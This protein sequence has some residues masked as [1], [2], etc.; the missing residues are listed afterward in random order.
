MN[1]PA[2]DPP[3]R[4][5]GL[6][7]PRQR[8][9]RVV[10]VTNGLHLSGAERQML[11]VAQALVERG[12][13]VA[14]LSLLSTAAF[15][16]ELAAL[17]IPAVQLRMRRPARGVSAVVEATRLLRRWRPDVLISFVY[18]ANVLGRLA[19]R[20]A[21]VG[22]VISS[23][24][25]ERFGGRARDAVLRATDRLA[26]ITT[27][28]SVLA[29]QRLVRD[30]VVP[31]GRLHVIGNAIDMERFRQPQRRTPARGGLGVADHEFVWLTVGRLE[32][33]KD[34]ETLLAAFARVH[35][36]RPHARLLIAGDGGLA[37]PLRQ[38][39][40]AIGDGTAARLV[41]ARSDVPDLLAAADGFVLS[42][43]WEGLP[44][45][46]MEA[47]AAGL[48]VVATDVGGTRELVRHGR[49]GF[50]VPA[51]DA[52]RLAGRMAETMTLTPRRRQEMAAAATALLSAAHTV[53]GI[54]ARWLA[55]IDG[56]VGAGVRPAGPTPAST[57]ISGAS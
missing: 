40:A 9:L 55:L 47:M 13:R 10:L 33:Q 31:A 21:G 1:A 37:A 22:V 57:Q 36:A 39:A 23:I 54:T 52:G 32:P 3:G 46:V 26:T 53:E 6:H 56:C 24:R 38:Q 5:G 14:V 29:A 12:D 45:V 7:A 15:D 19:G 34:H 16:E 27:V 41:G 28:N 35:D 42:S 2:P 49:T 51:G 17:G 30:R 50:L 44:N 25:N 43:R 48:P 11:H 18:Q 4:E 20:A 8:P